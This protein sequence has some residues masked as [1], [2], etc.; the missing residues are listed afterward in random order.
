[1]SRFCILMYHMINEPRTDKEAR[2][3]CPPARF[4]SHLEALK[5]AGYTTVSPAAVEG[6]LQ[7]EA[8]L[9][10]KS[11][12]I[13]ID[14]GFRDN[15]EQAFPVLRQHQAPALI[16]LAT[17]RIAGHNDWMAGADYPRR[18]M[19]TWDQVRE[20]QAAGIW[21]GGHTMT[22]PR[23]SQLPREQALAEIAG[24]HAT[25]RAE[26]G[27][28]AKWFAYPYGDL[29]EK[30]PDVA[31]EA[32]FSFACTTR[33][34][35]NSPDIEPLLLR[36]LEVYGTDPA[37]KLLQKLRFGTNEAS[38]FAPLRYYLGRIG[39]RLGLKAA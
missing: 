7:G 34:G 16:F 39:H 23:L 1:M 9:P 37:W 17:S 26:T 28:D 18:P 31:R 12:L 2:Y 13:T 29:D 8:P 5:K 33:S 30:T 35:F 25:L 27:M 24:S 3:A 15:Y 22:H 11:V 21:F 6:Y 38:L 4:A 10:P 36:R 20:M 19:L 32:G 14:D